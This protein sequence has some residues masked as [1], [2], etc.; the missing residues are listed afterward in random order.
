MRAWLVTYRKRYGFSQ[1]ALAKKV[2][3]SQPSYCTIESGK[4]NPSPK[5]AQKI[6]SVLGFD[7]TVFFDEKGA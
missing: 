7:W 2:G 4:T 3:I 5:T 1:K 6:A